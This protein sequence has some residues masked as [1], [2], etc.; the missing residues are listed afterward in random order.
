M[1]VN[2]V[3]REAA[4]HTSV[5]AMQ[6]V[7]II[8]GLTGLQVN[9]WS[10]LLPLT[11][12]VW[13]ATLAAL[14]WVL[15]ILNVLSSCL[16]SNATSR[17]SF[18]SVRVL[19]QQGEASGIVQGSP[20]GDAFGLEGFCALREQK[21]CSNEDSLIPITDVVWPAQWWWWERLVLGL[22]ML[23]V[24]VLGKSYA[25][26]LMSLLAVRYVPQPFQTLRDVLDHP[27]VTMIWQ[28]LSSYEQYIRVKHLSK[29]KVINFLQYL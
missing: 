12:L 10:F 9:P 17:T 7:R 2:L 29:R 21:S 13:T 28:K 1:I 23:M 14:L 11:A 8:N 3:R 15:T 20:A 27:S 19:L 6:N 26:N 18:R 22:W 24:L 4:G 16:P 25:G 5:Y